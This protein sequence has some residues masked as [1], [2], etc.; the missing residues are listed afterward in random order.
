MGLDMYAYKTKSDGP[1]FTDEDRVEE[2]MY[3]RKH[4]YLH[5]WMEALFEEKL[6]NDP[7]SYLHE[8]DHEFNCVPLRLEV[9]DL[10]QLR[11]DIQNNK[12]SYT[13]GF[14]FGG[15][16]YTKE[17]HKE[18]LDFIDNALSL[19]EEGYDIYYDSWW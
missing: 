10:E 14:F 12:L 16:E 5:G 2:I 9:E 19:I 15:D 6:K 1:P 13:P 3:W 18:D 8:Y 17:D 11:E 7:N 4:N